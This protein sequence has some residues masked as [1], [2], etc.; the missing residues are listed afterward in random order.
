[1]QRRVQ[2]RK[3]IWDSLSYM[4]KLNKFTERMSENGG[5]KRGSSNEHWDLKIIM[6]CICQYC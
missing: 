4:K 1:M 5:K 2:A 6:L 3:R